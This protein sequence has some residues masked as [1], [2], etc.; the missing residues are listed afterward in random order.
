MLEFPPAVEVSEVRASRAAAPGVQKPEVI[1]ARGSWFS[2]KGASKLFQRL[3]RVRPDK[4]DRAPRSRWVF[5]LCVIAPALVAST[6]LA[7]ASTV[8]S[9]KRIRQLQRVL[10]RV[11]ERLGLDYP[12][13]LELVPENRHLISVESVKGTERA[14]L[15]R[16]EERMLEL[17]GSDE[18][19]AALAHELGHV[20][21][22]THHP[23]LQ[24]EQLA[25]EVAMRVVS[26]DALVR[27]YGKVWKSGAQT[28]ELATF[29]G[30]EPK[31]G[32]VGTGKQQ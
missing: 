32:G 16:V 12:I 10:D 23:Y 7:A 13:T 2:R 21:V 11:K 3:K 6:A 25:N 8:A 9:E 28:G 14:F 22:F 4:P 26:R 29:L 18:L 5:A 15:I 30:P 17:L 19:E 24:T 1:A 20:W 31:A 27:V